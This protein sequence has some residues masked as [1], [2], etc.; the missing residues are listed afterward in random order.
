VEELNGCSEE[1]QEEDRDIRK[2]KRRMVDVRKKRR[3][4]L[5]NVRKKKRRRLV[6][7]RKKKGGG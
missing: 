2:K 1:D 4:R 6:D 5:K 7:A 3:K